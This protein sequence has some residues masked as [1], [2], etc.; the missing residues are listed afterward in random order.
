MYKITVNLGGVPVELS[1][2]YPN[3][4][5]YYDEFLTD[6]PPVAFAK[7]SAEDMQ[8]AKEMFPESSDIYL[9]EMKLVT[10]ASTAL[11]PFNR[12]VFHCVAFVWKNKAWLF[13]APSGTGKSTQYRLWKLLFGSEVQML[14]GDKPLLEIA[15]N[16]VIVHPSPWRGK[17]NM[18]NY[19]SAPLGGIV[20]LEQAP[21]NS[22][23]R[24]SP[25][26]S[27]GRIYLQFLH[28]KATEDELVKVCSLEHR[29]LSTVP[30]W[31]L[32]NRGDDDSVRLCRNTIERELNENEI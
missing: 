21:V 24:L 23:S 26:E 25:G 13:A 9:E 8:D 27:A 10:A 5:P 19:I 15:E 20:I 18:G 29:I 4:L 1:L 2:S 32:K 12:V 30:V 22:I 16:A 11:L 17:E 6:S 31:L 14:N 28:S 7:V 3:Y